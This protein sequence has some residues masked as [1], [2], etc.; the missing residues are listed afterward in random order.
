M[1]LRIVQIKMV[2]LIGFSFLIFSSFTGFTE[3]NTITEL[4]PKQKE[5]EFKYL[6][7]L[8]RE[9]YPFTTINS[10]IKGLNNIVDLENEYINKAI[11]TKNNDEYF[12]VVRSY[13]M[14]LQC[15]YHAYICW[16][17]EVEYYND[18]YVKYY[19]ING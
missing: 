4:T 6:T 5:A 14:Q 12:E 18:P 13:V 16:P 11:N 8:I 15:G 3:E 10:E 1:M 7:Q 17:I 19:F 2:L 9:V